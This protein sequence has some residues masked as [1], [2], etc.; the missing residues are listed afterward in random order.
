MCIIADMD[1]FTYF[2]KTIQ[3]SLFFFS[4][5]RFLNSSNGYS[6]DFKDKYINR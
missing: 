5:K 1:I 4:D 6:R 2:N 3:L